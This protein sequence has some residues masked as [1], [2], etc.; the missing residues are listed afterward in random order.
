[1][2]FTCYRNLRC[3]AAE[4]FVQKCEE[5]IKGCAEYVN[6]FIEF[7]AALPVSST[8]VWTAHCQ[9]WERDWSQPNPFKK[10]KAGDSAVLFGDSKKH[11]SSFFSHI[12]CKYLSS[13][14]TRRCCSHPK[15]WQGTSPWEYFTKYAYLPRAGV[16]RLSVSIFWYILDYMPILNNLWADILS[17][18][19]FLTLVHTQLAFSMPRYLNIQIL[20]TIE[21]K[22]GQIFNT[23]IF[24]SSLFCVHIQISRVVVHQLA[25]KIL[26]YIFLPVWLENMS[27]RRNSWWQNGGFDSHMLRKLWMTCRACLS[28]G[29][30]CGI[31]RAGTCV[32]EETLVSWGGT[33][34]G[35]LS[36]IEK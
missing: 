17:H 7:D 14:G 27:F 8:E 19:I 30:W 26:T 13:F 18:R 22:L 23:F 31:Q 21:S 6:A 3:F 28:C 24:P 2:L 11:W 16:W 20:C 32:V 25:F 10:S 35:Q 36:E 29:L 4:M 5:A 33:D 12:R 34:K 15:G 1:M 9:A